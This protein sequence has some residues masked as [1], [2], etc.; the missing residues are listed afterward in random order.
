MGIT[1][2]RE[3]VVGLLRVNAASYHCATPVIVD[4][5]LEGTNATASEESVEA[6]IKRCSFEAEAVD[7][8]VSTPNPKSSLVLRRSLEVIAAL[9]VKCSET[10]SLRT[11]Q[12]KRL[13]MRVP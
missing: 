8:S 13:A 12:Y 10:L 11:V 7:C 5:R 2:I 3:R 9:V 4:D 6:A 1:R